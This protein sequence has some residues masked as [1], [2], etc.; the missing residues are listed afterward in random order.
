[1]AKRSAPS[2][3]APGRPATRVAAVQDF[4]PDYSYVRADLRRIAIL[5]VSFISLLV[6][7]SFF[8][9]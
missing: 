5:A 2:V 6:V 9:D 8:I 1:M 7:L 4:Q 3:S